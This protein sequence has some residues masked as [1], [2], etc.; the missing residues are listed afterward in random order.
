[1][2]QDDLD[3]RG[4][5]HRDALGDAGASEVPEDPVALLSLLRRQELRN[6]IICDT[7]VA[8][9]FQ[10]SGKHDLSLFWRAKSEHPSLL[11]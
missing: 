10:R 3:D 2:S 11:Q 7:V 6:A 9:A 5:L 1:M 4:G 8:I